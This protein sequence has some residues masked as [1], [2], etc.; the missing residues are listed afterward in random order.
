VTAANGSPALNEPANRSARIAPT[1]AA[2]QSP[3][4]AAL[5]DQISR[6]RRTA[7]LHRAAVESEHRRSAAQWSGQRAGHQTEEKERETSQ[8][9]R[10]RPSR[11]DTLLA[12]AAQQRHHAA[13]AARDAEQYAHQLEQLRRQAGG[14]GDEFGQDYAATREESTLRVAGNSY[15][16]D[17]GTGL[18]KRSKRTN[19]PAPHRG[20]RTC[21][22]QQVRRLG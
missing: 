3:R 15:P 13:R 8:V 20:H 12:E 22:R 21:R 6:L 4:L 17:P 1:I 2:G 5:N 9:S 16:R 14:R 11:R 10:L 19:A 7:E 18:A